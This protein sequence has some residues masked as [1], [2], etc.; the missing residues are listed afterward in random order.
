MIKLYELVSS[1]EDGVSFS[2]FVIA[3]EL[4]LKHK[5]NLNIHYYNNINFSLG[6]R[7]YQ[8]PYY[9]ERGWA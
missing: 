6:F 4:M 9:L 1:L 8:S 2:P 3:A 5:V 7:V